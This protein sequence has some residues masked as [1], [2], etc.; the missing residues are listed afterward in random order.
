MDQATC[1]QDKGDVHVPRK[2]AFSMSGSSHGFQIFQDLCTARPSK[3][4]QRLWNVWCNMGT[5]S[6]L[7]CG[8]QGPDLAVPMPSTIQYIY[9]LKH[10][11]IRVIDVIQSKESLYSTK[12]L[13]HHTRSH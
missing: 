6:V 11:I 8:G 4:D 9:V 5:R 13:C 7:H 1:V 12:L 2:A 3:L 10:K